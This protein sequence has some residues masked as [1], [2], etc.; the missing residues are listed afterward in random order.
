MKNGKHEEYVTKTML[1]EAVDAI[2]EGMNKMVG[3][4]RDDVTRFRSEVNT[5]F[6]KVETRLERIEAEV[7]QARDDVNGLTAELSDTPSRREFE[8]LKTKVDQRPYPLS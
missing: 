6:D 8:D 5:G 4:L 2:L 1:D 3:G 7:S